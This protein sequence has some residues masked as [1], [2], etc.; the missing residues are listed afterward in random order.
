MSNSFQADL[1]YQ[2]AEDISDFCQEIGDLIYSRMMKGNLS[3]NS[4]DKKE[5][6]TS[7]FLFHHELVV[8]EVDECSDGSFAVFAGNFTCNVHGD[9]AKDHADCFFDRVLEWA[10]S[11]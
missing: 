11:L 1:E 8:V 9:S 7:K 2:R 5:K 6:G 4:L 3:G 10:A